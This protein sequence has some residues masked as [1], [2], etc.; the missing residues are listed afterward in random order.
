MFRMIFGEQLKMVVSFIY[1]PVVCN[2][3]L[4][5]LFSIFLLS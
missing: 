3:D 4:Y 5:V 1:T 2:T